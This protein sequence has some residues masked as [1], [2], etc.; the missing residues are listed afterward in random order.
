KKDIACPS[1]VSETFSHFFGRDADASEDCLGLDGGGLVVAEIALEAE[2]SGTLFLIDDLNYKHITQSVLNQYYS[3]HRG[4]YDYIGRSMVGIA[5]RVL[6]EVYG[7]AF[8]G[9]KTDKTK[10]FYWEISGHPPKNPVIPSIA[11]QLKHITNI[12]V[13]KETRENFYMIIAKSIIHRRFDPY[14][15]IGCGI[16]LEDAWMCHC[17]EIRS[18]FMNNKSFLSHLLEE[19]GDT[20]IVGGVDEFIDRILIDYK[21]KNIEWFN[22]INYRMRRL[23]EVWSTGA[24]KESARIINDIINIEEDPIVKKV[25]DSLKH[26]EITADIFAMIHEALCQHSRIFPVLDLSHIEEIRIGIR[27]HK[28]GSDQLYTPH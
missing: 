8:L 1:Y 7:I 28:D 10:G 13:A 12:K 16:D 3:S 11:M 27:L 26:V 14:L 19:S 24:K 18:I 21:V 6:M 25:L 23:I 4:Q 17:R 22:S 9:V 15:S 20:M 2:E 5:G